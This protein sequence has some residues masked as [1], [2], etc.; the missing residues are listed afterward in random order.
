MFTEIMP[1]A[2]LETAEK[3]SANGAH[4]L[5]AMFGRDET[6]SGAGYAIYCCFEFPEKK[7]IDGF[8]MVFDPKGSLEYDSITHVVPGA[9]WYEREI[10]DM[11]GLVP[12]GHPDLRPLVLHE[13]F[14]EN[15]YP[16]RK[17]VSVNAKVQGDR[18]YKMR[19]AKGEGLFEVPVGPI[20]A[21]IIEPGHFRF[22]Q[23]GEAMLQLD[24]KL[25]YTHRGIEK[26]VEGKTPYEALPI[27][28]RICGA[29]SIANT[30]SFC[31]GAEKIAGV[32]VPRRAEI[33]RTLL[34]ELERI[35]NH[36]GDLGNIP[37]GVG[38]NPAISLGG[39][40]KEKMMRLCEA[41]AGN[42]FL[43][44][45]IVPGGVRQDITEELAEHIH[46]V[47]DDV[48]DGVEDLSV[49]FAEQENFQNRIQTTGIVR[50][51]TAV[52][53]AMVGVGARAS[54]FA[55]DS[56]SDFD[57]GVYSELNFK[58]FTKSMGDVAARIL[59][60]IG[61]LS[62]SFEMVDS[63]LEMLN[64]CPNDDL[65]ADMKYGAGEGWGISE[66]ARGSNFHYLVLDDAGKIDRLFVRSASYPNW[67]A[68]TVAVQGDIIPDF[69]LINKSFELCY[70]CIDR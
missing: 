53:L 56:R 69:P 45:F 22:S 33:I 28:E 21:G 54:G 39:R 37:A 63:L 59:V 15:F 12:K 13:G 7:D 14:P 57:Y 49:M 18:K 5:T 1:E 6:E 10:R 16:L 24:A 44:G 3:Y 38:F 26:A 55:H 36:V 20:H 17:N 25:F 19:T 30:W 27:I 42:R 46:E 4:P 58:P 35:T 41:V 47:L 51:R 67:P 60:R 65:V 70:A 23:A 40:L 8:K 52:D 43:R 29:C 48:A 66:S 34:M 64:G 11:F 2:V 50:N 9:A 68:L 61:E 32:L 31:Q 62:A